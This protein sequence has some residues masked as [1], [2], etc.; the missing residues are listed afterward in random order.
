M[1]YYTLIQLIIFGKGEKYLNS[2]K[3]VVKDIKIKNANRFL[4]K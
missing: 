1:A 4:Y 2:K 3:P